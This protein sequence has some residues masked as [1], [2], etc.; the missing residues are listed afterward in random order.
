MNMRRLRTPMYSARMRRYPRVPNTLRELTRVLLNTPRLSATVD[1]TENLYAWS[2]TATDGSHHIAFFSPRMLTFMKKIK[3][4]QSDG[5][6]KSRPMA[7]HS[8]QVYVIVTTWRKHV[9]PL[10]WFL[11]ER[12]SLSAYRA[13]FSL[14][15]NICP[16][17][18]PEV[19]MSDWEHSQQLAWQEAFPNASL[20]GCLWHLSRAFIKKAR[21]LRLMRFR[22]T[23]PD[24]FTYIRQACAIALLPVEFFNVG[25]NI[26]KEKVLENDILMAFLLHPF[27]TYVER[28]WINNARRRNWMSLFESVERTNNSCESHNRMLRSAVG[29]H[30][31]NVFLFIEAL[32][33]LEHNASLDAEYMGQGG[34]VVRSR[35]WSTLLADDMLNSL[36]LDLN[37]DLFN[38]L[39]ETVYNYLRRASHLFQGAFEQHLEREG[40]A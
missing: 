36:A 7:P 21:K 1:G 28:R 10:G 18:K 40:C 37:G 31:P 38:D 23:L 26:L 12:K 19:I 29:A 25:L 5:T 2:I 24:L 33:K 17:F 6:F 35:R 15:K 8:A 11:M 30:R 4:V 9:V 32:D 39:G 27:F 20:Q 34:H 16:D 22:K 3:F 14:L 13:V